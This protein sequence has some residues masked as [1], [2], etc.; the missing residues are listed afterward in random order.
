MAGL[1]TKLIELNRQGPAKKCERCGLSYFIRHHEK[2]PHCSDLSES[3]LVEL[4]DAKARG[5]KRVAFIGRKMFIAAAAVLILL[6][7]FIRL[8][9]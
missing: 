1:G 7:L 6:V 5:A 2:C 8:S 9:T 3:E 4:V